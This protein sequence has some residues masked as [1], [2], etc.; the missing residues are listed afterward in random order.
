MNIYD[1]RY[2]YL[3]ITETGNI[4]PG[5]LNAIYNYPSYYIGNSAAL[6]GYCELQDI[7][8]SCAAT[9][10]EIAEIKSLLKGGVIF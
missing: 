9:D 2:V 1:I 8:L 3:K 7:Q 10:E 5:N 4:K 6:S